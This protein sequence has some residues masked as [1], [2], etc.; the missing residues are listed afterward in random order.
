[1]RRTPPAL[2]RELAR[3]RGAARRGGAEAHRDPRPGRSAAIGRAAASAAPGCCRLHALPRAA[4]A[5]GAGRCGCACARRRSASNPALA[6]L[7]TLNRLESVMARAEWRDARDLGGIDAGRRRPH[8]L[9]HD[10]E[11]VPAARVVAD[12]A[13]ARSLR[14][15][16]RDAPLGAG[17]GAHLAPA[18][19]GRADSRWED[20]GEAEEVFMTN[21][22]AGIVSVAH[23]PARQE[24][25]SASSTSEIAA[26]LRARLELV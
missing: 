21:A 17:A 13:D 3:A 25:H 11:P 18:G 20:L 26:R 8:G 5:T 4:A 16:R 1:M 2:R 7:K 12:D 19:A 24:P 10:V 14:H 9:R 6:G 22:V 23:H 15:R